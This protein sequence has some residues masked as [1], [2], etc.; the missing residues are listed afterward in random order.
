MEGEVI[1][2]IDSEMSARARSNGS[3]GRQELSLHGRWRRAR[4]G[5]GT[6]GLASKWYQE[7][8]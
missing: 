7:N 8:D 6:D 1:T 4:D 2:G 3:M 5:E